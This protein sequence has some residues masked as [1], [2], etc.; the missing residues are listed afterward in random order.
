MDALVQGLPDSPIVGFTALLLA[1]LT[2]PPLAERLRLPGLVGLLVAGILLG[3]NGLGL[4]SADDAGINLLSDVGKVYLMFVAGLE[5]DLDEFR[6]T[7][8]RSLVFGFLT[9]LLPLIGGTVLGRS[10]GFGWNASILIG[11]LLSSHTLLGFPIVRRLGV[12]RT[13]PVT[14]TVGATIITDT[15]A[16]LVLAICVAV[17]SGSFSSTFLVRQLILLAAYAVA[18]LWGLDWAGRA[19]FRRT[20]EQE[21]NQFLFVLLGMFLAAVVAQMINVDKIVGAFLA[22]LAI[23]DVLGKSAVQD[24]VEFLGSTL[25]IPCFFI[26]MGLLLDI[27]RFIQSLR[28]YPLLAIGLCL[29]LLV[30]KF[31]ASALIRLLYHYTWPEALTMWSLSLPQ[32]AA[33]L[34]ATFVG[35]Q[36]GLLGEEVFNGVIVLMLVTSILGPLLT[37]RFAVQLTP[38]PPGVLAE[39]EQLWRLAIAATLAA[40]PA[41]P[42][43][44]A[45]DRSSPFTLLVPLAN[46]STEQG[47]VELAALVAQQ[48]QGRIIPLQITRPHGNLASPQMEH[49]LERGQ[50]LLDRAKVFCQDFNLDVQPMLR[51]DD[52]VAEGITRAARE[53]EADLILMGSS[54]FGLRSRLMVTVSESVFWSAHCPVAVA[55]LTDHPQ[56]IQKILVPVK[57]LLPRTLRTVRFAQWLGETNGGTVVLLHVCVPWTPPE[58]IEAFESS[59][60]HWLQEQPSSATVKVVTLRGEDVGGVVLEQ[61]KRFDLVVL[62]SLRRRTA[63]GFAVSTVTTQVMDGFEGSIVLFGEPQARPV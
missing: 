4:L 3:G 11:S 55:R 25:F 52:D 42:L 50:R 54:R 37:E 46:P 27:P 38:P 28:S 40:N 24:K 53:Q 6:K 39:P 36:M 9:F 10:F 60:G 18:V 63:G 31:L 41:L 51:I 12:V 2:V 17:S 23:N 15:A 45:S 7:R 58:Q 34:A 16:L 47:L 14:V 62:R 49:D 35:V 57:D 43:N 26:D 61:V 22:G 48:E 32:V 8:S 56:H 59:L 30:S 1:I 21:G 19:Y 44:P 33:T 20:G 5:I 13:E 29:C